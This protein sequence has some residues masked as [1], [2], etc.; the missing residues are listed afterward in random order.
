LVDGVLQVVHLLQH[1]CCRVGGDVGPSGFIVASA[2]GQV[3]QRVGNPPVLH[4]LPPA[5]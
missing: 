4:H 3:A 1:C 5:K 2:T